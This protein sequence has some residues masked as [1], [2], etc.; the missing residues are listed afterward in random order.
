MKKGLIIIVTITIFLL[1]IISVYADEI[2]Y[3]RVNIEGQGQISIVEE[4]KEPV[5]SDETPYQSAAEST[6]PGKKFTVGAK[7]EENFNFIKWTLD[8]KDYSTE[9][10]VT[11][12][13][14]KDMELIAVFEPKE[15]KSDNQLADE[16]KNENENNNNTLII[17]TIIVGVVFMLAIGATLFTK[18]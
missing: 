17:M 18:S 8:G 13:V 3:L 7:A 1:G 2:I 5:F 10:P 16:Q 9:N 12:T 4:G 14:E 11:V 6:T 15:L